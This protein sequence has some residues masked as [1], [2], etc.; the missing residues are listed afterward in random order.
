M[1]DQNINLIVSND[2]NDTPISPEHNAVEIFL[3]NKVLAERPIG[4]HLIR[5]K[6]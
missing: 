4:L 6:Y 1:Y 5:V 2:L 3:E